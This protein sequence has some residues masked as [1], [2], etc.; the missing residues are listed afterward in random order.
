MSCPPVQC[1]DG[2]TVPSGMSCPPVQCPDG[3][4]VPNGM[5]CPPVQCPDGNTVPSGMSCPDDGETEPKNPTPPV[6]TS[7]Y[8][9]LPKELTKFSINHWELSDDIHY[10]TDPDS[11]QWER[12]RREVVC[13]GIDPRGN[14][15]TVLGGVRK[16]DQ[17]LEDMNGRIVVLPQ[18]DEYGYSLLAVDADRVQAIADKFAA[19]EPVTDED[20]ESLSYQ[21]V[22]WWGRA[23]RVRVSLALAWR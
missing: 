15:C 9:E 1:P 7:D 18:R 3:N 6:D 17:V 22:G 5:S 23:Q 2:S 11:G 19:M 10:I 16:V 21:L 12:V 4:T 8:N 13:P 14:E 20:L